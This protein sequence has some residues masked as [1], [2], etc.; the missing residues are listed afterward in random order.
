MSILG[1]LVVLVVAGVTRVSELITGAESRWDRFLPCV[2]A[3]VA[4]ATR[5]EREGRDATDFDNL[6]SCVCGSL[7]GMSFRDRSKM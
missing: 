2:D 3:V 6:W 1:E 4:A 7:H 5:V